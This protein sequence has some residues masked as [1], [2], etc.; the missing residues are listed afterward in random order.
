[1]LAACRDKLTTEAWA[2][3]GFK[4]ETAF[5]NFV[6]GKGIT[7]FDDF[8]DP[9]AGVTYDIPHFGGALEAILKFDGKFGLDSCTSSA[10]ACAAWSLL[11]CALSF[12]FCVCL[13]LHA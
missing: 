11:P 7:R 6:D 3:T 9:S 12:L 8:T 1:M 2:L 13:K 4:S 10:R 5:E